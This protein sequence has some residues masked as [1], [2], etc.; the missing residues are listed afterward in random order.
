MKGLRKIA[1][2]IVVI[3]MMVGMLGGTF[4][5]LMSRVKSNEQAKK[6]Y[7]ASVKEAEELV[8]K[9]EE[10]EEVYL[11]YDNLDF[12]T[13][14]SF[15]V[16]KGLPI[17]NPIQSNME[18]TDGDYNAQAHWEDTRYTSENESEEFAPGGWV[19]IF[20]TEEQASERIPQLNEMGYTNIIQ[21]GKVLIYFDEELDAEA[22]NEY[23]DAIN[24][25]E[26]T[27]ITQ[28]DS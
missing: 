15:L 23:T 1:I 9:E 7:E 27:T 14:F 24:E 25:Y 3:V 10:K 11:S 22:V 20:D 21:K 16:Y 2:L 5:S 12:E 17:Q 8:K 26:T 6:E 28:I 4:F 18:N 19:E 13:F